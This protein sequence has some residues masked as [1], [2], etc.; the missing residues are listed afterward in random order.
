M[1]KTILSRTQA[2]AEAPTT[3]MHI[4]LAKVLRQLGDKD[5]DVAAKWH[6][7]TGALLDLSEQAQD[8]VLSAIEGLGT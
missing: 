7:A 3:A 6:G 1:T 8:K 5:K 2:L 4:A